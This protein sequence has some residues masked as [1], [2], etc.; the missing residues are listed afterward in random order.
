[1]FVIDLLKKVFK[2]PAAASRRHPRFRTL[3]TVE[4]LEAREVF[5]LSPVSPTAGRPF[6][7]IVELQATFPDHKSYVGSGVM[8]DR[9]H[10]LT[11]GHVIYSYA[12]GG[13]ASQI[14]A[15]PDLN[16]SYTPFGVAY[17]TYE[18]TYTTFMNY[19]RANPG[20]TAP[21]DY[22]IA[23]ITLDRTIGDRTG[24]MSF[25]YDNN[26]ADF[27]PGAILNTAG[28]PAAGGYDGRRMEF[29]YGPIA[30]LS[31]DGLAVE[32]WQ[33]SITTFAGQSGSPVWRY[34]PSNGASVV[35]GVHVGNFTNGLNFATR[36]TQSI[37]NDL[38]SWRAA[39]RTPSILSIPN[40]APG[41]V[42]IGQSISLPTLPSVTGTAQT[43][44]ALPPMTRVGHDLAVLLW[45]G[46]AAAADRTPTSSFASASPDGAANGLSLSPWSLP[47]LPGKAQ[48][49]T[50]LPRTTPVGHDLADDLWGSGAV[51][52]VRSHDVASAT[53]VLTDALQDSTF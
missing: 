7:A 24:W 4:P 32:Y 29:S 19:N 44:T 30:G 40:S 38:Q 9:F 28:Y 39:D 12:D 15:A 1:M 21:G 36:I 47:S 33:S 25:G 43:V 3:L 37:F 34:T 42:A 6:T 53:N 26:N 17:M 31:P 5:S 11:A 48:A 2:G 10:V 18:R 52:A 20:R 51:L 16:G 35:Y 45:G 50:P 13:F 14:R 46:G 22:D 23:L 41:S 8:V 27:A 49:V